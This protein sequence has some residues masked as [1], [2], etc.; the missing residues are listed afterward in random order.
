MFGDAALRASGAGTTRWTSGPGEQ[1][2]SLLR[3]DWRVNR[4]EASGPTAD[5]K[6]CC[7]YSTVRRSKSTRG[8][9]HG[10]SIPPMIPEPGVVAIGLPHA[11]AEYERSM[12]RP[13]PRSARVRLCAAGRHRSSWLVVVALV[14]CCWPPSTEA[15]SGAEPQRP[16][17]LH[18]F[19]HPAGTIQPSDVSQAGLN[20]ATAAF[21]NAWKGRY[22]VNGCGAN[23]YYVYVNADRGNSGINRASISISEG[24]G[25]GMLI[26]ALMA[27][28][29]PNAQLY[30]DGLYRFF[31]DHPSNASGHDPALPYPGRGTPVRPATDP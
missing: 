8:R 6:A 18:T 17:G 28:F 26:T 1:R 19:T 25:Y 31:K 5:Q 2:A 10:R 12:V 14:A 27:G 4:C 24:H 7:A 23:R 30:F 15:A 11:G 22:L 9:P 3:E 29:D 16:F 20:E 21:Y 13:R